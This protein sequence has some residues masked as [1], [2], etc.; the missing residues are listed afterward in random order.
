MRSIL[1]EDGKKGVVKN[2]NLL[3]LIDY[4]EYVHHVLVSVFEES[5]AAVLERAIL[6]E[7]YA[8][9]DEEL[10]EGRCEGFVTY[11]NLARNL[12]ARS[13]G[14]THTITQER[15]LVQLGVPNPTE[16]SRLHEEERNTLHS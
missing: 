15:D 13:S 1:G 16:S 4:P 5:G 14:R 12:Y 6:N 3:R 2:Y 10:P 11:V 9:I 7:L 8:R